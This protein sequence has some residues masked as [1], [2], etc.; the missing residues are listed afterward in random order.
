[1]IIDS[2]CHL[3]YPDFKDDFNDVLARARIN[4][5]ERFLTICTKLEEFDDVHKIAKDHDD[6]FCSLGIHP[7]H[8][9]DDGATDL[10][11]LQKTLMEKA[12]LEKVVGIGETGLD[13]FYEYS[14]KKYQES[15]FHIHADVA[16][17]NDLPLIVHSRDADLETVAVLKQHHGA[18]GVIHCFSTGKELL[19][20]A[21]DLGFYISIS[22]IV[23]FNKAQNLQELVK[24]IPLDR[25][26]VETDS[27][28][29]APVPYR[30][31]RNEPSFVVDVAKK[32]AQLRD[33]SFEEICQKTSQNFYRL[34]NKTILN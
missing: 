34:F 21:L 11:V 2:H 8:S 30:G 16:I 14:D 3:N 24:L 15:C 10:D 27:P 31:K 32:V 22:G 5:V 9:G 7:H 29:L 26:L 12:T 25:L 18:R 4:G 13:F 17:K 28:Y 6:I 19:F 1:M 23:T 33:Q 20:G